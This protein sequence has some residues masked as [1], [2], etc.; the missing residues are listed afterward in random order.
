MY[1]AVLNLKKKIS[2]YLWVKTLRREE[3]KNLHKAKIIASI[4]YFIISW[5]YSICRM[6]MLIKRS[7]TNEG[8]TS[9]CIRNSQI[10]CRNGTFCI[11]TVVFNETGLTCPR[12][13]YNGDWKN[14]RSDSHWQLYRKVWN[15]K[16]A[17]QSP[18]KK[19]NCYLFV[20]RCS[21]P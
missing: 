19:E 6:D 7:G 12:L 1:N 11:V 9:V 5:I 21:K 4:R 10:H 3:E 20:S 13:L 17:A 16:G 2:L 15:L 8:L 14:E 18:I